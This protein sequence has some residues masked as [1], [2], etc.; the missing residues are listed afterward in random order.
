MKKQLQ[1]QYSDLDNGMFLSDLIEHNIKQGMLPKTNLHNFTKAYYSE[2]KDP[3]LPYIKLEG[4]VVSIKGIAL[5]KGDKY[6]DYIKEENNF[7]FKI[8]H[9]KFAK[10]SAVTVE[11]DEGSFASIHNIS[12]KSRYNITDPLT[13]PSINIKVT[14]EAVIREFTDGEITK[15]TVKKIESKV[16]EEIIKKGEEMIRKFQELKIDPLGIGNHVKHRTREW[17]K[18]KWRDLYPDATIKVEANVKISEFGIID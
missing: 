8:L 9:E 3:F 14:T 12:S 6:V 13:E 4:K 1:I 11:L 7:I 17:D 2:G 16:E 5:F 18:E 10:K 15:E